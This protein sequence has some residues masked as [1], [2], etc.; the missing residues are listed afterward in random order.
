MVLGASGIGKTCMTETALSR[1]P[2]VVHV[3]VDPDA[4]GDAI[5]HEIYKALS[6][7]VGLLAN[8]QRVVR[9]CNL[10][11]FLGQAHRR[12]S[13][14]RRLGGHAQLE[15]VRNVAIYGP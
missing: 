1:I 2:V 4:K 8:A 10:V 11:P 15:I 13:R 3:Q 12:T 9:W 7:A 5:K 14:R 6:N